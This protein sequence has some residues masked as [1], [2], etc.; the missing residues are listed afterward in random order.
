MAQAL[1]VY[2]GGMGSSEG[3]QTAQVS[4][5]SIAN[6]S[7]RIIIGPLADQ[8]KHR[9]RLPRSFFIP[10]ISLGFLVSQLVL[11]GT[12][13]VHNLWIASVLLGASYGTIVSL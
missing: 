13:D 2:A 9:L 6:F 12:T 4:T 5:I 1:Y 3:W 11:L 8:A 7:S 10:V